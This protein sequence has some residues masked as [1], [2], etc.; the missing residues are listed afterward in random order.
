V[1]AGPE[2]GERRE[3]TEDG[4]RSPDLDD[5]VDTVRSEGGDCGGESEE[6]SGS[7]VDGRQEDELGFTLTSDGLE[8]E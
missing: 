4:R 5:H 2:R 7:C 1:L 6:D 8:Y 3:T